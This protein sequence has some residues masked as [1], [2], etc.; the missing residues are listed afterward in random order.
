MPIPVQVQ[1]QHPVPVQPAVLAPGLWHLLHL[2]FLLPHIRTLHVGTVLL[3]LQ[4]W[5]RWLMV[6]ITV[7]KI[8]NSAATTDCRR[9]C[10]HAASAAGCVW[11]RCC[12]ALSNASAW[13]PASAR[14]LWRHGLRRGAGGDRIHSRPTIHRAAAGAAATPVFGWG[15]ATTRRPGFQGVHSASKDAPLP[16][17]PVPWVLVS[18][19][20]SPD[21]ADQKACRSEVAVPVG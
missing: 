16:G 1:V 20:M 4:R 11:T 17:V 10:Q 12:C 2:P 18:S 14:E 13:L 7:G 9:R 5:L 6:G 15:T 19:T 21:A 8:R 3:V